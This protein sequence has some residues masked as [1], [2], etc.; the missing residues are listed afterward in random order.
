MKN[1]IILSFTFLALAANLH[2]QQ[3]SFTGTVYDSTD[4]SPLLGADVILY[5]LPENAKPIGR[6]ADKTGSFSF[7][8]LAP[9]VYL[10][11]VTYMG[12]NDMQD[13]IRLFRKSILNRKLFLSRSAVETVDIEITGKAI[14]A[15]QKGDTIQFN[16]NA[17][18]TNPDAS[19]E[20]LV[21]KVP[22]V[23]NDNG[24]L[25][26][27]GEEVKQVFVDGKQFFGDDPSIAL[28]NLPADVVDKIQV[29]DRM[30]DQ[31]AFTGFDDGNTSKA[32]N[33]ITKRNRRNGKFGKLYGGLG[34]DDRYAT[35]GNLNIFNGDQ[36]ITLLGLGNNINRQN[37]SPQDILGTSDAASPM[38]GGMFAM[39][40]GPGGGGGGGGRRGGGGGGG[41]ADISNF[42]VSNQSG[43]TKTYSTGISYADTWNTNFQLNS[44]YFFNYANNTNRQSL[45]RDYYSLSS[46][47][48][49]YDEQ[50]TSGSD[51]YNHRLNM[52]AEYTI[53]TA[54]SLLFTPKMSFQDNS[55]SSKV[56][57]VNSFSTSASSSANSAD[58]VNHNS[59]NG[60]N[61]SGD[62]LFRH[63]FETPGRTFS[64]DLNGG[65]NAKTGDG[66]K[67]S[68]NDIGSMVDTVD[69]KTTQSVSG[70]SMGATLNY[71]EPLSKGSILQFSANTSY[72]RDVSDK[73]GYNLNEV[74]GLYDL[75]DSVL[76]N[77]YEN[78]YIYARGGVSYRLRGDKMNFTAETFYQSSRLMG[79]Q[80]FPRKSEVDKSFASLL[81][82]V[83][84]QYRVSRT[85]NLRLDYST[86]INPPSISQLQ[87]TIDNTNPLLLK[88]GNPDLV[89]EYTHRVRAHYMH[90]DL[91]TGSMLFGML[92]FN[93]TQHPVSNAAFTAAKDT[94]LSSMVVLS[95]GSQLTYPVNLDHSLSVRSFLN[96]GM[97]ISAIRCNVNLFLSPSYGVSPGLTNGVQN[98]SKILSSTQGITIASNVSEDIDFRLTYNP[99][100]NRTRNDVAKSLDNVYTIQNAS[101]NFN[102]F[103][104]PHVYIKSDFT[105]YYNNY[106]QTGA[107]QRQYNLWN[108]GM[109]IKLFADRSADL[110]FE[111]FDILNQNKSVNRTVTETY[112][113][114]KNSLVIKQYFLVSFTYTI[115]LFREM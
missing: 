22:G 32:I 52:R 78:K 89:E 103:I 35:G 70:A 39:G 41:G 95:R 111:V 19:A 109:G 54:N 72:N 61:F 110:K 65:S 18:K 23:Q 50:S 69:Q 15:V 6:A 33:I 48:Q 45:H 7:T 113:E 74:T 25:K 101:A 26:A 21:A 53:D 43:I 17:F 88:T 77:S 57:G 107:D 83:R 34:S 98:I 85:N 14:P 59:L 104:F 87:N 102:W 97:M 92:M 31:A 67:L 11:Q 56:L 9:A 8:N 36:R 5:K 80:T 2:G 13:T 73:N 64:V 99:S 37:F 91:E 94:A 108:A 44:S 47:S 96:Y 60:N 82:S 51:N 84:Y 63:K 93:Y 12:Y 79:D 100:I 114:D 58:Y 24:T 105:Y 66:G 38:R 90:T 71:T 55:S 10:L 68:F 30:S 112:I 75:T 86:S 76:S 1:F 29:Y 106:S 20:D 62:L 46:S 40:G 28:R 49:T 42:M 27:Q 16:A 3:F 115:K 4:N 81:P